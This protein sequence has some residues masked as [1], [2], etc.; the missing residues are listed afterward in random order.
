MNW[1]RSLAITSALMMGLALALA[2]FSPLSQSARANPGVLYAAP[3]AQGSGNC[4]SWADA[5][6][7]QTALSRAF[8]GDEIWVKAGVHY[9]GTNCTDTF[10]LRDNVASTAALPARNPAATSVTGRPASQFSA[11][12]LIATTS[13][14]PRA[15]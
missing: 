15:W 3:A 10:I 5:C 11:A 6:T 9:P 8:G 4:S 7:L 2:G 1:Q 13:P 12:T 14:T